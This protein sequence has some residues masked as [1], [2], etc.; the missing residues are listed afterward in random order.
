VLSGRGFTRNDYGVVLNQMDAADA[1]G[2]DGLVMKA[3]VS[4][5]SLTD[6]NKKHIKFLN[7]FENNF[8]QQGQYETRNVFESLDFAWET[9]QTFLKESLRR[10]DQVTFNEFFPRAGKGATEQATE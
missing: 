6:D 7:G 9:L 2:K 8:L 3:V 10:I 4:E 1:H 5:E